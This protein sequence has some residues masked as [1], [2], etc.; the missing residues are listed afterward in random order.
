MTIDQFCR[1]TL[2]LEN[3]VHQQGMRPACYLFG[4]DAIHAFESLTK[5]KVADPIPED[6]DYCEPGTTFC[7]IPWIPMRIP[8]IALYFA[9]Y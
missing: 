5:D 8:G 3:R 7:N 6:N 4:P 1:I 9:D 2:D